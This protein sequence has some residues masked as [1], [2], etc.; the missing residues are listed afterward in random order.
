[1]IRKARMG[2]VKAIQKLIAEYARKGD[3]LPRSLSEIY[4]LSL[5]DALPINQFSRVRL[6]FLGHLG[7]RYH[8]RKVLNPVLFRQRDR[9]STRLNSSH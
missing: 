2:D 3:M 7:S 4:T 8:A 5:H 6:R 1:M 9:K